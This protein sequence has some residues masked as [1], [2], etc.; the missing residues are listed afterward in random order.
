MCIFPENRSLVCNLRAILAYRG[1]RHPPKCSYRSKRWD[2][3]R[4]FPLKVLLPVQ[5][6]DRRAHF[7]PQSAPSGPD[8][9]PEG[10]L[11]CSERKDSGRGIS[12]EA[13]SSAGGSFRLVRITPEP[14]Y[15]TKPSLSASAIL[16][17]TATVSTFPPVLADQGGKSAR[18]AEKRATVS[19]FPAVLADQGKK[20]GSTVYGLPFFDCVCE[21]GY[22]SLRE[23][24]RGPRRSPPR[25]SPPRR[26]RRSPPR[27]ELAA[28]DA[29][30]PAFGLRSRL[31]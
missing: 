23:S 19:T 7:S 8:D 5:V 31:P 15:L 12:H 16:R 27:S 22:A 29:D 17:S 28:A 30:T 4:V 2:D 3:G 11:W 25:R 10:A 18:F 13:A 14:S 6:V 26:S 24:R 9:G 1:S 21:T 20:K